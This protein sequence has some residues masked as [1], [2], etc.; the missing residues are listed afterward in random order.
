MFG[1][2]QTYINVYKQ[3]QPN[4]AVVS[5]R[6]MSDLYYLFQR[7]IESAITKA[8]TE[9]KPLIIYTVGSDNDDLWL[10]T[11]LNEGN[12]ENLK[13]SGVLLKLIKDTQQFKFFSDMIPNVVTP[14][15]YC[16][17]QNN[18]IGVIHG[19]T[20][21][22]SSF[23]TKLEE[24]LSMYNGSDETPP[25]M[26]VANETNSSTLNTAPEVAVPPA[27]SNV[28]SENTT[29]TSGS[30]SYPEAQNYSAVP[31]THNAPVY[32]LANHQSASDQELASINESLD[33]KNKLSD[34][35]VKMSESEKKYRE[36]L[37][38]QQ[39]KAKE[40][41][42]RITH[43]LEQDKKE[44]QALLRE[45]RAGFKNSFD[46][47]SNLGTKQTL[48]DNISQEKQLT[49][50][51]ALAFKLTDGKML[52]NIFDSYLTL[53]DVRK[54]VD[55]HRTDGDTPFSFH[56][57]IPRMTFGD[58]DELRSLKDLELPPR[59]VLILKTLEF[60]HPRKLV[61]ASNASAQGLLSKMY[62]GMAT[63][64]GGSVNHYEEQ[65][66]ANQ[67]DELCQ[68]QVD[69]N[70]GVENK[71]SLSPT[72]SSKSHSATP[73]VHQL[74]LDKDKEDEPRETYNGNNLSLED[75]KKKKKD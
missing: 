70:G 69:E 52:K 46:D 47:K 44:R 21:D 55:K 72:M 5:T 58:A 35:R 42:L 23:S 48:K 30:F 6:S 65:T 53:N 43:L 18:L 10:T 75:E 62:S 63:W 27:N 11:W 28:S 9:Q 37:L 3:D 24:W 8:Q 16:M 33:Q 4:Q 49:N 14:A 26:N 31:S 40:E 74:L 73:N 15:L 2:I 12:I 36:E 7:S 60:D 57:N 25:V 19:E 45:Q 51:C 13:A 38:Q 68:E 32:E 22:L 39:K 66:S 56:R 71:V 20:E 17:F 41:K 1:S 59:S 64:W 61:H 50:K 54:W 67:N 34:H 29:T